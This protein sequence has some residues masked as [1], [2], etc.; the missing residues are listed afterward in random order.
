MCLRTCSQPLR[1]P[2]PKLQRQ[3]A[4][5]GRFGT[6]VWYKLNSSLVKAILC[7]ANSPSAFNNTSMPYSTLFAI[8]HGVRQMFFWF[9]LMAKVSDIS[10]L[11]FGHLA[12]HVLFLFG[13]A[14]RVYVK[15]IL[16]CLS[17]VRYSAQLDFFQFFSL[18][19]ARLLFHVIIVFI[20]RRMLYIW[21][22]E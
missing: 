17:W 16:R 8:P 1:V 14:L 21:S 11:R 18:F 2:T 20:L 7:K 6:Q 9:V 12:K 15:F 3:R 19:R 22:T 10:I 13:Y 4:K 5:A